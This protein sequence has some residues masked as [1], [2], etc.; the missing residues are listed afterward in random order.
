VR[1]VA[2]VLMLSI[3]LGCLPVRAASSIDAIGSPAQSEFGS[4]TQQQLADELKAFDASFVIFDSKTQQ[5]FR[6][7]PQQ[8]GVRLSPCSTF[9]I[10]NSLAGLESGVLQSENQAFSWDGTRYDI[11]AWNR[12]QTLQSAVTNSVV[13][14]FQRVASGIG[15]DRMREFIQKV[16]YG[17]E[18]ISG[19][20]T[21]FWLGNS[22]KI[23]ADEQVDFLKRL[24]ND[25]LPFSKRS[26]AI[27]RGLIRL[28][29]TDTGTLYGKTGSDMQSGKKI[30]GWFVGY[31]VQPG[32]T[33]IFA[34]NIKAP[35]GAWGPKAR[36]LTKHIL[37]SAG[38][39]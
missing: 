11:T 35:D 34:T 22:L 8:C 23:S 4:L 29:Q 31:V 32:R 5:Y 6:F 15:E 13:W 12:D 2:L 14:Y 39:L 36:E 21:K 27:V 26:M 19:G 17:N 28:D 3:V 33:Y 18:D 20:I 7:N 30:L 16:H 10:F 38:L 9:K 24:V 37:T 1:K 25:E